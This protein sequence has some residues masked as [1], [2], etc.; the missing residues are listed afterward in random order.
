MGKTKAVLGCVQLLE[1]P[2]TT[3]HKAPLPMEFSRQEYWSGLPFSSSRGSSRTR[4]WTCISE[5]GR[6]ISLSLHD[7]GRQSSFLLELWPKQTF[8]VTQSKYPTAPSTLKGNRG[9]TSVSG[10]VL[11]HLH[12]SSSQ[13]PIILVLP[14]PYHLYFCLSFP[15]FFHHHPS[16]PPWSQF[17]FV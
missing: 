1:T 14:F 9:L 3:A 12:L 15:L 16:Y 11:W 10:S 4:D 7:L 8:V 13:N 5:V 6:W 2:W 17:I